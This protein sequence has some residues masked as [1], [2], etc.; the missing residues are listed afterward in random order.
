MRLASSRIYQEDLAKVTSMELPWEMLSGRRF[1]IS[2]ATG[3]IGSTL[4]DV[5]MKRNRE[6]NLN[7][8]IIALGRNEEKA[9]GR[10]QEYLNDDRFT[11]VKSDINDRED[12][13]RVY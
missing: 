4:I 6:Q 3:M 5:L 13:H 10:F 9:R 11:F 1:V 7:C 2:G 12:L 8:R